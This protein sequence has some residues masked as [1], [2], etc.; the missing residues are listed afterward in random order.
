LIRQHIIGK[1]SYISFVFYANEN[2]CAH[3]DIGS[4]SGS[5]E[6]LCHKGIIL[7]FKINGCFVCFNLCNG[8]KLSMRKKNDDRMVM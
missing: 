8:L 4:V 7:R 1:G 2:G 3:F 6:D 5:H